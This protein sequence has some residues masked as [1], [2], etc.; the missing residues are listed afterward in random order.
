MSAAQMSLWTRT[1]G[2]RRSEVGKALLHGRTV[3]QVWGTRGPV[4]LGPSNDYTV[5]V[6]G[7][8]GRADR[9]ARWMIRRGRS[10]EM[11]ERLVKHVGGILAR[12]LTRTEVAARLGE[13]FGT[14]RVRSGRGWGKEREVDAF[15][16]GGHPVSVGGLLSYACVRGVAC[17]G[18]PLANEGTFVRPDVWFPRWRDL[19]VRDAE[20]AIL[21]VSLRAHGPATPADFAWWRAVTGTA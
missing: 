14:K 5:F 19:S 3:A 12:P 4:H 9:D 13:S 2:L 17:A 8:A 21:R 16:V 10:I 6:R 18:P 15:E 20:D 1:R 7:C 11:I